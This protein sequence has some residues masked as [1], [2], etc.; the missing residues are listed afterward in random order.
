MIRL[1]VHLVIRNQGAESAI[2]RWKLR[3]VPPQP[4]GPYIQD[5]KGW[6]SESQMGYPD[7]V[8]RNLLHDPEIIKR[9]GRKEGWLLCRGPQK[10]L[11]LAPGQRPAVMVSF[12]DVHDN[13]YS[14][15]YPPNFKADFFD[16]PL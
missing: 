13:E 5:E 8:G 1:Y 2:D 9:G 4:A 3:V 15:V 6:L 12:K 16:L 11:G 7:A 10:N 14:V